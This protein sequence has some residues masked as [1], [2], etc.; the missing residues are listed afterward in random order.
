MSRRVLVTGATGTTGSAVVE[1]L[2]AADY[3][4]VAAVRD[5]AAARERFGRGVEYARF[6]FTDPATYDALGGADALYLVRPP[7]LSRVHRD[8]F[9]VVDA[10]ER[11]GVER[12]VFL[13][14]LGAE[15]APPIPHRRIE[16]RL[17]RS[18]LSHTFLRA[19]YF[20]Q[21]LS[22]VHAVDVR[23]RDEV[24]VPAGTGRVGMVDARDVAAVAARALVEPDRANQAYDL[25]G[26]EAL[27]FDAVARTLS[28]VLGR[29]IRYPA[30]SYPAFVRRL[31][32]RGYP[33]GYVAV[34]CGIYAPVRLHRADRVTDAVSRLLGR[35]P[36]SFEAFAEGDRSPW[37]PT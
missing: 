28:S 35:P 18:S 19:A 29:G 36:R 16:R 10:A 32:A 17:E 24:Y 15:K 22:G 37:S 4:A 31:R 34:L 25:T 1:S 9:P 8:V 21:N 11:A 12:V 3:D 20:M 2:L 6:D 13:S 7:A 30:P 23:E 33:W 27:G 26:P 5:V 14:V